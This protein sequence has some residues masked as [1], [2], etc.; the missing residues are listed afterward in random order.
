M[1]VVLRDLAD[2]YR[3]AYVTISPE[4][5]NAAFEK[6]LVS[7]QKS[8]E[9]PG[10][11]KGKVPFEIIEKNF[12]HNLNNQ[13][14]SSL[15]SKF[16]DY[17]NET[18]K[19]ESVAD[20]RALTLLKKGE[21]FSFFVSFFEEPVVKTEIKPES[22]T[23]EYDEYYFDD[24]MLKEKISEFLADYEESDGKI[25]A[26]DRVFLEYIDNKEFGEI[27]LLPEDVVKLTGKKKGD[28]VTLSFFD[29]GK[30]NVSKF[31]GKVKE[32]LKF[33]IT[34]VMKLKKANPTDESVTSK[35]SFKTLD[36]YKENLSKSWSS[37]IE[38]LNESSKR[39]ALKEY[40]AKNVEVEFNKYDF[41]RFISNKYYRFFNEEMKD[42][43]KSVKDLIND[44][45]IRD[46]LSDNLDEYYKEYLET[47]VL[48][49]LAKKNNVKPKQDYIDYIIY[50]KAMKE[51]VTFDEMKK[52]I[53]K[54]ELYEIELFAMLNTLLDEW[55]AKANFK[56]K[57]KL[58]Y[59]EAK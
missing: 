17:I 30:F 39:K 42:F 51:N 12:S 53:S 20:L 10:Y 11:R 28:E 45:K 40:L 52:S 57:N 31:L 19:V 1:E 43:D 13:V 29:L 32:P 47:V 35:T 58:P 6:E 15:F 16:L 3:E 14:F 4:E 56:V 2:C 24:K 5:V 7:L 27:E 59:T 26:K 23:I 46:G 41:F 50:D 44:K 25:E 49:S 37:D 21:N 55:V 34:K 38:R 48:T 8:V 36:E 54:E 18:K 33:K 9:F 22:L